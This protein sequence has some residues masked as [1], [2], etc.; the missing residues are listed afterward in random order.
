MQAESNDLPLAGALVD[1][2]FLERH[3]PKGLGLECS[4]PDQFR[5]GQVEV[6]APR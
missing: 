5:Y 1:N 4:E 3:R 6:T 2:A